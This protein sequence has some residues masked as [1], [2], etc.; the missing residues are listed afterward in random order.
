MKRKRLKKPKKLCCLVRPHKEGKKCLDCLIRSRL[1]YDE[2]K[3]IG[4]DY[5][6]GHTGCASD[7]LRAIWYFVEQR[8]AWRSKTK[9]DKARESL[10]LVIKDLQLDNFKVTKQK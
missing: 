9:A 8:W 2:F 4:L 3:E 1:S 7:A 10:E 6:E 5:V